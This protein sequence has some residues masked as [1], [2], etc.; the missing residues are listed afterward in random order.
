MTSV[1]QL[2]PEQSTI[3]PI[4]ILVLPL[5]NQNNTAKK[6]GSSEFRMTCMSRFL[7]HPYNTTSAVQIIPKYMTPNLLMNQFILV[8]QKHTAQTV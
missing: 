4:L 1:V 3:E 2:M 7:S 6:I 8:N 5:V